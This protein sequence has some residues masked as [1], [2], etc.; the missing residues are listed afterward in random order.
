MFLK[1]LGIAD[2]QWIVSIKLI[3]KQTLRG[4]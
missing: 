1:A 3:Q 4:R 2:P